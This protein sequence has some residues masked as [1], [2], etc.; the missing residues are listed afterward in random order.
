MSDALGSAIGYQLGG[1]LPPD[2]SSYVK[3]QADEDLYAKLKAGTYCYV[4]NSR[5]MGK[6]SLRIRTIQ[7]LRDEDHIA[8]AT[9]DLSMKGSK[10]ITPDQWY[11]GFIRDLVKDFGLLDQFNLRD[12]WG[13]DM[14]P[15]PVDKFGEFIE[16]VLLRLID[17]QIVIFVDE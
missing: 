17:R 6:S 11:Y 14:H 2:A 12:W 3:R 5:Q 7:R 9:I 13:A 8:C 4:L 16:T 15:S 1:S 10:G